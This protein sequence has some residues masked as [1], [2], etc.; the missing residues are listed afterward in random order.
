MKIFLFWGT[1]AT[2]FLISCSDN[3]KFDDISKPEPKLDIVYGQYKQ[4][5]YA[6]AYLSIKYDPEYYYCYWAI[7]GELVSYDNLYMEKKVSYGEHFLEFILIDRFGDTLSDGGI[8]RMNEPLKI[9]LLSPIEK[10][11]AAKTDTVKFQYKISGIDTWEKKSQI[12]VYI[13]TDED[14]WKNGKPIKDSFSPLNESVYYWGVKAFTEQDTAYSEIR[15]LWVK[16]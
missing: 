9:T 11:Q 16:N 3:A 12:I 7:D 5:L 8:V 15:S 10:Y 13:S 2:L 14:I 6:N 4:Y 1:A